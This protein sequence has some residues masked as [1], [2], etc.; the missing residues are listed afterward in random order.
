MTQKAPI[1]LPAGDLVHDIAS[2]A[3]LR[4]PVRRRRVL[5]TAV[6][7]VVLTA[8]VV[9]LLRIVGVM[10][11]E[12]DEEREAA[13]LEQVQEEVLPQL[14]ELM[15]RRETFFAAEREYLT[16]VSGPGSAPALRRVEQ[17]MTALGTQLADVKPG[18]AVTSEA[19]DYLLEAVTALRTDASRDATALGEGDA[20]VTRNDENALTSI[21]RMNKSLLF[22]LDA[23]QLP[24]RD[25]DLPGGTDKHPEDHSTTM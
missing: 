24:V 8:M 19:H 5:L 13:A 16:A 17:D 20:L 10:G 3:P 18:A 1:D 4:D 11:G 23:A 22:V 15:A 12:S 25:F 21:K 2:E 14:Q 7:L 6:A 9:G